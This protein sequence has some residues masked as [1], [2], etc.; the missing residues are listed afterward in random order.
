MIHLD[1]WRIN[2]IEIV[3]WSKH[4]WRRYISIIDTGRCEATF[5][6]GWLTGC[7]PFYVPTG[8]VHFFP[9]YRVHICFL[10]ELCLSNILFFASGSTGD[11]GAQR[12]WGS[13]GW[14][15]VGIV[16]G[17][18]IDWCSG[19]DLLKDYTPAFVLT[20]VLG[21]VDIATASVALKVRMS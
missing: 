12:A 21:A 15:L 16:S 14:G 20:L 6:G 9:R 13:V 1:L 8:W 3:S 18:L 11:Y 2:D 19:E 5:E 4:I 10:H 7:Q 17:F